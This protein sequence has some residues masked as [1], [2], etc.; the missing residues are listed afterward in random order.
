MTW[1][2]RVIAHEYKD[3]LY[4]EI[5]EVYYNDDGVPEM[6][7]VD[8]VEVAGESLAALSQ[9]LD[10]MRK[11]LREPILNIADFEEGGK[12]YAKDLFGLQE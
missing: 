9:T 1:N 12:Y 10:W 2:Y 6:C 11:A 7:T 4:F 8:A 5:H 3:E